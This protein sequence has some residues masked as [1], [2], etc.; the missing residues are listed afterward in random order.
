[1][2]YAYFIVLPVK[3]V[4]LK[5]ANEYCQNAKT[6]CLIMNRTVDPDTKTAYRGTLKISMPSRIV[7]QV[8]IPELPDFYHRY[9]DIHLQLNSSDDLTDLIE[10]EL[11]VLFG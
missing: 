5:M 8:I 2:E 9:P 3:S 10:K 6:C 1:M 7:H 4:L 11:T